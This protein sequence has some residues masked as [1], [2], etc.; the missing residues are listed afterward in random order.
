MSRVLASAESRK[1]RFGP[2]IR[3][4][5]LG[6]RNPTIEARKLEHQYPHA[7]EVL[8]KESWHQ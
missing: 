3:V 8:Y 7:L 2:L 6:G 5:G 1:V 4:S